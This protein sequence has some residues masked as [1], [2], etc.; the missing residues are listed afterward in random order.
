MSTQVP[1]FVASMGYGIVT[2]TR[3]SYCFIVESALDEDARKTVYNYETAWKYG[4]ELESRI[5]DE[6]KQ[7]KEREKQNGIHTK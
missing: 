7:Q 4:L 2:I 3:S 6:I 5:P 1:V